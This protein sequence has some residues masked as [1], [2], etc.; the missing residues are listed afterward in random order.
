MDTLPQNTG[1]LWLKRMLAQMQLASSSIKINSSQL[2]YAFLFIYKFF[3]PLFSQ[4]GSQLYP[5]V[6]ITLL[7]SIRH[8]GPVTQLPG[9]EFI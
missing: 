7:L 1:V 5:S 3:Y 4:F 6:P 8:N 2:K 9:T